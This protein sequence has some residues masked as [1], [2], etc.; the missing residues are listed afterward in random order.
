VKVGMGGTGASDD[1]ASAA[2]VRRVVHA[3]G[4]EPMDEHEQLMRRAL[5]LAERG[6][7]RVSPNPMVG[8]L[9]VAADGSIIAE[10]WHEG[11]GTRHAELMALERAGDRAR[12]AALVTTLEPCNRHGRTPPCTDALIAAGVTRFVVGAINPDLGEGAPGL[13]QL[14]DAGIAVEVGVLEADARRLNDAFEHHVRTGRPFVVMKSASSLDGKTAAVDGSSRWITSE[15]ARAD[16][17]RLRAWADAIL[18]GSRTVVE[19]DP[20]LTVRDP[21]FAD[22]RPPLRVAVDS[23][24]RLPPVG[25][26]FDDAAP[27]LIATTERTTELRV[28]EWRTAGAEVAVL[29]RDADDGVSL[30]ALLALLGSRDVQ[31]LLVEAG[32]NLAWALL[33]DDLVDRLVVYVAPKILGGAAAPGVVD[34]RG[35]S[36]VSAALPLAFERIERI[37]PDLKVEAHVHRDR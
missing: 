29:D 28:A 24:G 17:Q 19:D 30:P 31:G 11:P 20:A 35:F 3:P 5:E 33:R 27:T 9:V 23:G 7:G 6:W 14:R 37:G 36:P 25:R 26:L 16:V 12:G 13:A 1:A 4:G 22:A 21:R 8:A 2:S 32:A 18:V 15:D 10:G 34:G